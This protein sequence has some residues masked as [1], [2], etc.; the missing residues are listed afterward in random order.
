MKM[1]RAGVWIYFSKLD[2]SN[3]FWQLVVQPE[4]SFNFAYVLPQHLGQPIKIVVLSALQM[5]W[6]ESLS[7]FCAATECAWDLTQHLIDNKT[8]LRYHPIKELMTILMVP[9]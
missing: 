8:N 7:Y 2:I 3:G 9:P 4:D 5:G 6:A 1:T